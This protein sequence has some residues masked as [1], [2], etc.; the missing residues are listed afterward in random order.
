MLM[1]KS[2][3]EVSPNRQFYVMVASLLDSPINIPEQRKLV[4]LAE[5]PQMVITMMVI[6]AEQDE[7]VTAVFVYKERAT[8]KRLICNYRSPATKDVKES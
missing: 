3:V 5:C 6:P 8:K 1:S 4:M 7:P 2:I